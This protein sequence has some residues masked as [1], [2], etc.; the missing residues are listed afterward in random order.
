L[1][2]ATIITNSKILTAAHCVHNKYSVT[3]EFGTVDTDEQY[4]TVNVSREEIFVHPQYSS[5]PCYIN[6][7]AV[8]QLKTALKFDSRV[9]KIEMVDK[10]YIIDTDDKVT[11]LGHSNGELFRREHATSIESII[12]F[13]TGY[14]RYFN[15]TI[16]GFV[17][18]RRSY[19]ERNNDNPWLEEERQFC[20]KLPDGKGNIGTGY[21]GGIDAFEFIIKRVF[22]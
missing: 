18:C 19:C 10:K 7:L 22:N 6:D 12:E 9:D 3:L 16:A 4:K 8:I 20:V 5:G 17:G 13:S 11:L 15:S 1:C 2:S 14:L 21:A